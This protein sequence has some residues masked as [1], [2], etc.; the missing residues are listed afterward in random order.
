MKPSINYVVTV[1]LDT[2]VA[3]TAPVVRTKILEFKPPDTDAE[4]LVQVNGMVYKA[5]KPTQGLPG[6]RVVAKEAGMTAE[7]DDDGHYSFSKLS[8]GKHTFQV[9]VSGKKV[10]EMSVTIPSRSYD[11]EV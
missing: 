1:P 9:L 5:G 3:F 6:A 4:R 11:L 8:M 10:R 2:D 7:T